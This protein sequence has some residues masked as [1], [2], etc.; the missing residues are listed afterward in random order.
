MKPGF[1]YIVILLFLVPLFFSHADKDGADM[2]LETDC[3]IENTAFKGG[4]KMVYKAYYNWQFVW[5][6]SLIHI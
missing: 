2:T 5:I 4:E 1:F 6:L 3:V